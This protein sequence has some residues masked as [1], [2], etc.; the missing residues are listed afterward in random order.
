MPTPP[1]APHS[2]FS[3]LVGWAKRRPPRLGLGRYRLAWLSAL[4][5]CVGLLW[6]PS[7]SSL[8]AATWESGTSFQDPIVS[9]EVGG[10]DPWTLMEEARICG[11]SADDSQSETF[12]ARPAPAAHEQAFFSF[13]S[14]S[15]QSPRT[16]EQ[17]PH[18]QEGRSPGHARAPPR[19]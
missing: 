19:A 5:I 7:L 17:K 11:E 14:R 3:R 15:A 16:F 8:A 6:G 4:L 10:E 18:N 13:K 12:P 9:A 1:L 2:D